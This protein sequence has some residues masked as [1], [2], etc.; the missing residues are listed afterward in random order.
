[1]FGALIPD[2]SAGQYYFHVQLIPKQETNLLIKSR[3]TKKMTKRL[4][5]ALLLHGAPRRNIEL[6]C[7]SI[8][9]RLWL[10]CGQRGYSGISCHEMRKTNFQA[11]DSVKTNRD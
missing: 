3:S 1:M 2:M 6:K 4:I 11:V 7:I 8:F 9:P 5:L 10:N